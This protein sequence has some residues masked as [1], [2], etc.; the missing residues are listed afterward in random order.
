MPD[1]VYAGLSL[2]YTLK[3]LKN[4]VWHFAF[5]FRIQ[6]PNS[7]GLGHLQAFS[8]QAK[9]CSCLFALETVVRFF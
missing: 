3:I 4:G 6:V 1:F 2:G 7:L 5:Y 9:Y 8:C